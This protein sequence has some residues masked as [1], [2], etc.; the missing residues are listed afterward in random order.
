AAI[1]AG[2]VVV[3]ADWQDWI[4]VLPTALVVGAAGLS[5]VVALVA[6][7]IP[8]LKAARLQPLATLRLG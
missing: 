4:V 1:G 6:G 8:A 2:I 3:G 5:V 7:L